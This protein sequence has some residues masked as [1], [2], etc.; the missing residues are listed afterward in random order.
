M[1]SLNSGIKL[2]LPDPKIVAAVVVNGGA[3]INLDADPAARDHFAEIIADWCSAVE[4]ALAEEGNTEPERVRPA[5]VEPVGQLRD[6]QR[7]R[8]YVYGR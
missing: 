7:C 4:A 2:V 5:L 6:P 1:N 8:Q 3:S